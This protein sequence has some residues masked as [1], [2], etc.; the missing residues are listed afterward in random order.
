MPGLAV[1]QQHA[2]SDE[3][4]G[5]Q[6]AELQAWKL[7]YAHPPGAMPPQRQ[8]RDEHKESCGDQQYPFEHDVS[9]SGRSIRQ[10]PLR[11]GWCKDRGIRQANRQ[12]SSK[13]SG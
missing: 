8:E 2:L 7:P 6:R 1:V 5:Q 9:H 10:M 13:E 3:Q 11:C 4:G 12:S